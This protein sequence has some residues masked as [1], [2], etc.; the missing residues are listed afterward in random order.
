MTV[1]AGD[2][3]AIGL[4]E[5]CA[6]GAVEAAEQYLRAVT[7][8]VPATVASTRQAIRRGAVLQSTR[9]HSAGPSTGEES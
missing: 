1:S 8:G 2:A 7:A 9:A 4:V 3:A 5:V 6:D